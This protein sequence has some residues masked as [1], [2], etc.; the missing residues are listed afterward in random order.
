MGKTVTRTNGPIEP[1]PRTPGHAADRPRKLEER[2][3][4]LGGKVLHVNG[5]AAPDALGAMGVLERVGVGDASNC[6]EI[7]GI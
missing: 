7:S 3:K 5:T 4:G 2:N 6:R 1:K